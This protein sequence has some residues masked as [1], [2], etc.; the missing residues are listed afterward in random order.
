[1]TGPWSDVKIIERGGVGLGSFCGMTLAGLGAEAIQGHRVADAGEP[2]GNR[3]TPRGRRSIAI[4]LKDSEGIGAAL[5][6]VEGADALFEGSAPGRP[7]SADQSVLRAPTSVRPRPPGSTTHPPRQ[8]P[9]FGYR[10]RQPRRPVGGRHRQRPLLAHDSVARA[11]L[12]GTRT[13]DNWET[14]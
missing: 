1:M 11:S 2:V 13:A 6:L 4:D 14:P 12:G 8:R 5:G 9:R 10:R 3:M 7:N